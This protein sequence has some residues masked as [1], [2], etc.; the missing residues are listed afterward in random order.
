MFTLFIA[1]VGVG[2]LSGILSGLLGLGGGIIVVPALVALG[3]SIHVAAGTSLAIVA[4]TSISA[5]FSHHKKGSVAWNYWYLLAPGMMIGVIGGTLLGHH[6]SSGMIRYIFAIF[7]IILA[8]KMFIAKNGKI[9]MPQSLLLLG[10]LLAGI[11]AGLLGVGG[12]VLVIPILMGLGVAMPI[13]SGTSVACAFPTALVGAI[14][15]AIAGLQAVDLPPYST[16]YIYW[17]AALIVGAVSMF[18]APVGVI[19]AHRFP[20]KIIKRIFGVILVLIAWQMVG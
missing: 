2:I 6:L 4:I 12:G 9:K 17:P 7:C 16:G 15:S 1:Y 14:S 10:G 11:L 3:N 19:L 13:V 5:A 20:E 8:I 18:A